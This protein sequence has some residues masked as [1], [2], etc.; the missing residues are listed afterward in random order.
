MTRSGCRRKVSVSCD[1]NVQSR[2][3]WVSANTRRGV[4]D[5]DSGVMSVRVSVCVCVC[6][7]VF[8]CVSVRACKIYKYIFHLVDAFIQGKG[9][10]TRPS[11]HVYTSQHGCSTEGIEPFTAHAML[12]RL[13]I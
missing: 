7:C 6:V 2:C 9:V 4:T 11:M 1:C 3:T 13:L 8:V 5:G 10:L 12:E